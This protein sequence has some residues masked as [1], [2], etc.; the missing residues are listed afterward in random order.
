MQLMTF[1]FL[2]P[3]A[4]LSAH[5]NYLVQPLLGRL[6]DKVFMLVVNFSICS[7]VRLRVQGLHLR[8]GE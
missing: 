3:P 6:T 2:T 7:T 4:Q 5:D 8:V 1:V